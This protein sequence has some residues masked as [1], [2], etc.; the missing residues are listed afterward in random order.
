MSSPLFDNVVVFYPP[1]P[2]P[3]TLESEEDAFSS[4]RLAP[5]TFSVFVVVAL[6]IVDEIVFVSSVLVIVS[7][8]VASRN[9]LV[10]LLVT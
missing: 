9:A 6:F 10:V 1:L 8:V 7:V 5:L 3:T 2:N 4:S